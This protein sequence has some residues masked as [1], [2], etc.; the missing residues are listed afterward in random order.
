MRIVITGA[1]GKAGRATLSHFVDNTSHEVIATD[2]VAR[3]TWYP[4]T[5]YRADLTAYGEAVEV[6]HGADAVIHLANIPADRIHTDSLTLNA[7]MAMN[8]N[9]FLAA[10]KLDLSRVVYASSETTLGL[11]F[12]EVDY[13]PVD[14][15][16]Y[17]FP[18]STY[19]LSK[20]LTETMAEQ[21]S[22]WAG[23]PFIGLRLSNIFTADDYLA[24]PGF[25]KDPEAR[26]WNLF[27]YIDA[28]DV[29]HACEDAL[30]AHLTGAHAFVIAADD[31]ILDLPTRE[32][33]A[34]VHPDLT[35]P[36]S[37]G[38]YGT[39]LSN[40]AARRAIGFRPRHTWRETTGA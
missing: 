26:R 21:V 34:A 37:V 35:V 36:D 30:N 16:H 25:A 18:N 38:E 7:N 12:D 8:N 28:R 24:Q 17:P 20:V 3:P 39:L 11:P 33:L 22:R 5:Y 6:L 40:A 31:T 4:G 10:W 19:S 23:I 15:D 1:A 9:V 2:V 13:V 27:G 29:A 14:E 32:A